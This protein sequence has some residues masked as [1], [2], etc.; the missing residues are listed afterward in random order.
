MRDSPDAD[1][2]IGLLPPF[3]RRICHYGHVT[4]GAYIHA[5]IAILITEDHEEN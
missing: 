1:P 2:Q 3:G 5:Y 4:I